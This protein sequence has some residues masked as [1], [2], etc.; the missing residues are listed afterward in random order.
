[1]NYHAHDHISSPF[2]PF[3]SH[4]YN[5]SINSAPFHGHPPRLLSYLQNIFIISFNTQVRPSTIIT[6]QNLSLDTQTWTFLSF[7]R[8]IVSATQFPRTIDLIR[9]SFYFIKLYFLV[10]LIQYDL[11]FPLSRISRD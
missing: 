6:L 8:I 9:T 4:E 5:T 2:K 7:E 10:L 11:L 1:M 3:S